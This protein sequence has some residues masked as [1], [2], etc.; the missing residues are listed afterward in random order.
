MQPADLAIALR[1]RSAWEAMDLGLSMLQRWWRLVYVP[2]LL[3]AAAVTGAAFAA[4]GWLDRPWVA[5]LIVWWMKPLNDRVVLHVLS[6]AVFGEQQGWRAVF[7][8]AGQ[9]LRTGLFAQIFFR[10]WPDLAR[11][12]YLP[13]RQLEGGR[14][15]QARTRRSQLGRRM[16]GYAVWLTLSC[17]AFEWLV[18]Y[19]SL[20]LLAELLMPAKA[21]DGRD[22]LE[23]LFEGGFWTWDDA[24][25]YAAAIAI[26][27]PFYVAAGFGLYLNRRSALEGWDIEVALRR[28]AERYAAAV[29]AVVI[30]VFSCTVFFPGSSFA[31]TRKD[32]KQEIAEVLK[33]PEFPHERDAMVWQRRDPSSPWDWSWDWDFDWLKGEKGDATWLQA[34]GPALADAVR[35][36]FWIGIAALL[37]YAIWWAS[38]LI[39]RERE[40]APEPYQPPSALFGMELAP[41]TLP[42]DVA[43]TAAALAAQG[44]LREALGLLYRGALSVLV[45]R[46]GVMLMPS[47]T[48]GEVLSLSPAD[49]RPYLK[50]LIELW[51]QCAYARRTPERSQVDALAESYR[52]FAA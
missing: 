44:R 28:I 6:R 23:A 12:F 30:C 15:A 48:E 1:R 13:V 20:G 36:L 24:L 5:L 2:H 9:W 29:A 33:G 46:R 50:A 52:G 21:L 17:M 47:H 39:R 8:N 34:I 22:M 42:A 26:L 3:V 41:E 32:P 51:R 10:W 31:Q 49:N 16:H 37:A 43:G 18:L 4:G 27:E 25:A 14:G 7:A 35:V 38:R 45:H 19:F 11:S 40:P